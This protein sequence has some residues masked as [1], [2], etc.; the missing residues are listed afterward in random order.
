MTFDFNNYSDEE[1][2]E[3]YRKGNDEVVPYLIEKYKGLVGHKVAPLF[4]T[5]GDRD[6]LVQEGMIGLVKA[7]DEFKIDKDTAFSTFANLCI[8][9]QLYTT[10]T[11]ANRKKNS[12][13]TEYI[14]IYD[15]DFQ[16]EGGL[17]PEEHFLDLEK[18]GILE[19]A[20]NSG[21][22]EYE[23][24]VLEDMISGLDYLKIAQKYDKEPKSVDNAI[25]RIKRK[26]KK[27][28]EECS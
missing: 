10:L 1:L 24:L 11:R 4:L 27:V 25:Q 26:V 12:P 16:P 14:S 28:I 13:L 6:D 22:S 9:R 21:L 23:K 5:G 17:N 15:E 2:I 7:I 18:V 20:I 3:L 8:T 19:N